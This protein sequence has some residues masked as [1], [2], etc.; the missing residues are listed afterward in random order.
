MPN[1]IACIP[2]DNNGNKLWLKDFREKGK[3]IFIKYKSTYNNMP[4]REIEIFS[5]DGGKNLV[6]TGDDGTVL[7]RFSTDWINR[8]N[9]E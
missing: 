8:L 4:F 9:N 6:I 1:T 7:Y 5:A 3:R 2:A